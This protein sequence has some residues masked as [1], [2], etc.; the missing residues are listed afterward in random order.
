MPPWQTVLLLT[1][2]ETHWENNGIGRAL[3]PDRYGAQAAPDGHS[4]R[5]G[6]ACYLVRRVRCA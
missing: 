2:W 6:S 3:D 5:F 1:L 4:R